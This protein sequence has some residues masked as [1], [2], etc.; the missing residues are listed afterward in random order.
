MPQVSVRIEGRALAIVPGTPLLEVLAAHDLTGDAADPVVLAVING[1]RS[2]LS[3]PLWGDEHVGLMRLSH[4]KTRAAILQTLSA[5][6]A[7]ACEELF[8]E[9]ELIVDFSLDDGLHGTLG[10]AVTEADLLAVAER[11]RAIVAQDREILPRVFGQRT[12]VRKLRGSRLRYTRDAARHVD[13]DATPMAQIEG[14]D[15]IFQG[16]QLPSTRDVGAFALLPEPPG[17]VLLPSLPGRPDSTAEAVRRPK[18]LAALREWGA[19]ADGHGFAHLGGLNRWLAEGR[20]KELVRLCEARQG[21]VFVTTADRIAAL[22]ADGR[23]VLIAGPSSSGKTSTAKRLSVQLNV[24]GL[25]PFAL[26][27][28]DYFVDRDA[29]PRDAH[30]RLDYESID[31]LRL[32]LFNEHLAALLAGEAVR[33]PSYDFA[34]GRSTLRSEPVTLPRGAPLLVEGLHA[35]NP[36]LAA[37]VAP[38]HTLRLFVSALCHTNLD[39]VSFQPTTMP[40]VIRRIVRDAQFRGYTAS[41][42][43]ARWPQ[44]REGEDRWITPH[45]ENADL[46]FNSGLAYEMSVLK[47]WA[48]PRLAAVDP[49][50][51]SYGRA[52]ALLRLLRAHLPLDAG[53]VPPT[54]LLREFIGGSGFSY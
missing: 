49:D 4:P 22:P 54:S 43:L 37:T 48:E 18:L 9:R 46:I 25:Q 45:L 21:R 42:T 5:V 13:P 6:L 34:T 14:S 40:R 10:D 41:Q 3:L 31:A 29:T 12:L 44:V 24:L 30:G 51:P 32:D 38:E 50:D 17:F 27:L 23:L 8:P 39:N 35:L 15:L 20:A 11:M 52:R 2:P 7:V 1:Q 53:L 19:W 33:L 26:S 16:L 28:D 36:R 47:L